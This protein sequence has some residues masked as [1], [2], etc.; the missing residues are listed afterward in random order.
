MPG[1]MVVGATGEAAGAFASEVE[2]GRSGRRCDGKRALPLGNGSE[3]LTAGARF[4][5][6]AGF[7]AVRASRLTRLEPDLEPPLFLREEATVSAGA[8]LGLES[9][10][11][12]LPR[13]ARLDPGRLEPLAAG[14]SP[15]LPVL[16][17]RRLLPPAARVVVGEGNGATSGR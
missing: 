11:A 15:S 14:A 13:S 2:S 17:I 12:I 16:G 4:G 10:G 9:G 1:V 6:V 7:E 8:G 3:E 5:T